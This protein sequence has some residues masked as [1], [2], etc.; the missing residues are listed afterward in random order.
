MVTKLSMLRTYVQLEMSELRILS[1]AKRFLPDGQNS[2]AGE[3]CD[4]KPES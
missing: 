1:V 3:R 2:M 4:L